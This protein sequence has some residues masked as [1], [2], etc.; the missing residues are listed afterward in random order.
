MIGMCYT[1]RL[2]YENIYDCVYIEF[3]SMEFSMD[4]QFY[5]RK[6]L[7]SVTVEYSGGIQRDNAHIYPL[8]CMKIVDIKAHSV[9]IVWLLQVYSEHCSEE[10]KVMYIFLP[11][12][13]PD[14][15]TEVLHIYYDKSL[16]AY[17]SFK[18]L[19]KCIIISTQIKSQVNTKI[20]I[21]FE[22]FSGLVFIKFWKLNHFLYNVRIFLDIILYTKNSQ[23]RNFFTCGRCQCT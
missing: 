12:K 1:L 17:N 20:S 9:I 18:D 8:I 3:R 4:P 6:S 21:N 19:V 2:T 13:F 10:S 11:L 22:E 23:T 16:L 5:A 7:Q 14:I 15:D